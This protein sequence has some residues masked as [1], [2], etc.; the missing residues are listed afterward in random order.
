MNEGLTGFLPEPAWVK[1]IYKIVR[2]LLRD[3][4]I[5]GNPENVKIQRFCREA[6]RPCGKS[7][8]PLPLN[9]NQ[10]EWAINKEAFWFR[11]P[12]KGSLV[13]E[14]NKLTFTTTLNELNYNDFTSKAKRI[15]DSLVQ[16][17][18]DV[19]FEQPHD[20]HNVIVHVSTQIPLSEQNV[21]EFLEQISEVIKQLKIYS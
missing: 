3:G 11:G 16:L 8:G 6:I 19:Q 7:N 20:S 17:G 21:V 14:P 4:R 5:S 12:V 15:T 10:L 9:L 2:Y 1:E 18:L 13:C